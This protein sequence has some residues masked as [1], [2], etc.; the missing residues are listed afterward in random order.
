MSA[1]IRNIS[2]LFDGFFFV[3]SGDFKTND[4]IYNLKKEIL[5]DLD[6]PTYRNDKKNLKSDFLFFYQDFKKSFISY[7]SEN[8]P[9]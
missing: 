6:I 1:I 5:S 7:K 3:C 2:S 4:E 9:N 8:L